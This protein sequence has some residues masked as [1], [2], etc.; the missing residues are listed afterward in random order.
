MN[1]E[2][3][4]ATDGEWCEPTDDEILFREKS[5]LRR[6]AGAMLRNTADKIDDD[7]AVATDATWTWETVSYIREGD[8]YVSTTPSG[9]ATI[10]V[11]YCTE[12]QNAKA[13]AILAEPGVAKVDYDPAT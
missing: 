12:S 1:G 7:D 3:C 11:R 10:R 5:D 8:A 13:R 4:K 2:W 9:W 6:R